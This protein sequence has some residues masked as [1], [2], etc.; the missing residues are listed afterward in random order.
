MTDRNAKI[1][2]EKDVSTCENI[3]KYLFDEYYF[4]RHEIEIKTGRLYLLLSLGIGGISI[5]LGI[6]FEQKLYLLFFVIPVLV[7][8]SFVMFISELLGVHR[9]ESYQKNVENRILKDVFLGWE[10]YLGDTSNRVPDRL[11]LIGGI[12]TFSFIF[13][14]TT[15]LGYKLGNSSD[16]F[17]S[18]LSPESW[19]FFIS[20]VSILFTLGFIFPILYSWNRL[21]SMLDVGVY[22]INISIVDVIISFFIYTIFVMGM[23]N[24]PPTNLLVYI[25]A[26]P[27]IF[28]AILAVKFLKNKK[29]LKEISR[30]LFY[31]F[32][33]ELYCLN[34]VEIKNLEELFKNLE[35]F[36]A[37]PKDEQINAKR[38]WVPD[39][40]EHLGDHTLAKELRSNPEK[41]AEIIGKRYYLLKIF[42]N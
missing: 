34:N 32:R 24:L 23:L 8:A 30:S 36:E 10:K 26:I 13:F 39:W 2:V 17:S 38:I 14:A 35:K 12:L 42:N 40:I 29:Q 19:K 37:L 9:I 27:A 25:L 18:Q 20:I 41:F 15:F 5:L 28:G 21:E 16:I 1:P 31:P 7:I 3:S 11:M 22:K 33:K 6:A 4:L